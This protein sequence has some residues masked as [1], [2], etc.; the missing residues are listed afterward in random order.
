MYH[1]SSEG[2]EING[3]QVCCIY[4]LNVNFFISGLLCTLIL[5]FEA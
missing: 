2:I 4:A 5:T 3:T 1:N